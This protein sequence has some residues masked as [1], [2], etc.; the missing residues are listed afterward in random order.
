MKV[1]KL[2]RSVI[3]EEYIEITKS[4]GKNGQVL[5]NLP[6][7]VL[8]NQFIYWSERVRD[9]D[10]YIKQENQRRLDDQIEP[11][12]GWMYKTAEELS[13]ETML[14][15]SKSNILNH[16]NKLIE[17]GF[18]ISRQNPRYNWDKTK[19]YRVDLNKITEALIENGYQGIEGYAAHLNNN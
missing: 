15:L 16:I 7:A 19:Q 17:L 6:A 3:R 8:L 9:F 18:I 10:L 2:K 14:G 4:Y 13:K 5:Y 11:L 1:V 12:N